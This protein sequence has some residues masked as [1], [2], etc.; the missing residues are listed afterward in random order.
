MERLERLVIHVEEAHRLARYED[1]AHLRL[2]LMLLDSAAELILHRAVQGKVDMQYFESRLLETFNCAEQQGMA[3]SDDIKRSQAELRSTVLSRS[4][5]R[6]L[7]RNFDAKAEYL[8]T[9]DDLPVANVRVLRKVHAY[10]NEA[11]HRDKVRP[12]SLR[13]AVNIYSYLV[14]TM[15][16]DLNVT[17]LAISGSTPVGLVP[18]LGEQPWT[19]GFDAPTKIAEMLLASSGMDKHEELGIALGNHV[20]DRLQA[21][22]DGANEIAGYFTGGPSD[23][24]WDAGTVLALVQVEDDRTAALMTPDAARRTLVP[25]TIEDLD[26]LRLR[27]KALARETEPVAAFAEFADIEDTFRPV[28]VKVEVALIEIERQVQLRV[29]I[30]RGK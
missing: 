6:T 13:S 20:D 25:F 29:D 9:L 7:D 3:L 8:A 18:Y 21:L 16:R 23:E 22:I 19:V 1:E 24:E 11:H 17:G 15:M 2:A 4:R 12:G 28:E 27:A 5:L 30:A 10:R 14:I 26:A